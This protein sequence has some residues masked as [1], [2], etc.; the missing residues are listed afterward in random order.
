MA[1]SLVLIPSQAT[2]RIRSDGAHRAPTASLMSWPC[3]ISSI[4]L[5]VA[6]AAGESG[7]TTQGTRSPA[8]TD[9]SALITAARPARQV[10]SS[11][12]GAA[13]AYRAAATS[14][15]LSKSAAN[16]DLRAA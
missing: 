15:A 7:T 2:C 13:A 6:T 4:S 1:K 16:S 11:S 9:A 8:G 5:V 10:P 12:P 14:V 3:P